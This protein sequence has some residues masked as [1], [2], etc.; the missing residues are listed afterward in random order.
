[1][2]H[3]E[4]IDPKTK[5]T[6]TFED[7][8]FKIIL[9]TVLQ[10]ENGKYKNDED[11]EVIIENHTGD[12][13]QT[14]SEKFLKHILGIQTIRKTSKLEKSTETFNCLNMKDIA[15]ITFKN[16]IHEG[17]ITIW[18]DDNDTDADNEDAE[19]THS[20]IQHDSE[21]E[22]DAELAQAMLEREE[23]ESEIESVHVK[24]SSSVLVENKRQKEEILKLKEQIELLKGF[25]SKY[26]DMSLKINKEASLAIKL[27]L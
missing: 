11:A 13:L 22:L 8:N 5:K 19:S 7:T 9:K 1:M 14:V 17:I 26:R 12:I 2:Y 10:H 6:V 18:E 20:G 4:T 21:D 15:T 23:S 3:Y 25:V 27:D 16:K 24:V